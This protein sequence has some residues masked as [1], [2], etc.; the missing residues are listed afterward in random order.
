MKNFSGT[1]HPSIL[2]NMGQ[3]EL[4]CMARA[5]V[6]D[7][8]GILAADESPGTIGKRFAAIGIE[9]NEETRR[10]Y[11]ELLLTTPHIEKYISGVILFDETIRQSTREGIPFV[12]LLERKGIIPGI[13]VDRGTENLAG[14]ASEKITQGL[15]G[16]RD[17]LR[18]Y[19]NLG[20]RFA[21]WRAVI[22]IGEEI[23]TGY[24]INANA[25]ALARYA[26][27]CQERRLVPIVEPEVLMEG[28]HGIDQCEEV[29]AAVLKNVFAELQGH[30]VLL[31]ALLLKP[32]MVLPG[33]VSDERVSADEVAEATIRCLRRV[34]PAAVPGIVFLS[35]G[36]SP[37][38]ATEHLNAMNIRGPHP[39]E[40]SFSYSRA[41][42]EPVLKT[43]KGDPANTY[44][45]QRIFYHRA[46]CNSAARLGKYSREVENTINDLLL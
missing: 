16:L 28:D 4:E 25:H 43:W 12:E 9:S 23:P 19:R 21:K 18:E 17:R 31:E 45:A 22:R 7:G 29:T 6:P 32:S 40:L 10:A 27:V 20:A 30:R 15:D 5:L 38:L 44:P 14:F 46:K 41:L 35:G 1:A 36:Q 34:A 13:K 42:Q 33:R 39:W 24:C 8:K 37:E 11:R 26:A 3:H 2:D